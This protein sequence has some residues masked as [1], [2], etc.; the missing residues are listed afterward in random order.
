MF[1]SSPE[2]M[3]TGFT[4]REKRWSVASQGDGTHTLCMCPFLRPELSDFLDDTPS[5]PPPRPSH[6]G[7]G[8]S[9]LAPG[10]LTVLCRWGERLL[11]YNLNLSSRLWLVVTM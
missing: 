5:P 6:A 11:N 3:L 8:C 2:D 4:E 9:R 10:P 7:G 1:L